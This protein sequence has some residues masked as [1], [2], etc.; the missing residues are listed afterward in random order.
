MID[1]VKISSYVQPSKT[2]QNFFGYL[3]SMIIELLN[4]SKSRWFFI[5]KDIILR[6]MTHHIMKL[7][8]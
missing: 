3:W 1:P 7:G 5:G 8:S 2:F 4:N 6:K